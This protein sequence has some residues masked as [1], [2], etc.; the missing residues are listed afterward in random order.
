MNTRLISS[1]V[2]FEWYR[3]PMGATI[4]SSIDRLLRSFS[5]ALSIPGYCTFTATFSPPRVVARCTWPM[6]AA[7]K[8]SA[9]HSA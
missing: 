7:A 1:S 6:L 8:G 5:M 2:S 4:I 9:S 3:R